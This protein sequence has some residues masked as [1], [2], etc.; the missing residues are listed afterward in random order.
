M[1]KATISIAILC[2]VFVSGKIQLS[3]LNDKDIVTVPNEWSLT[4]ND[5]PFMKLKILHGIISFTRLRY[6]CT[7]Q[8]LI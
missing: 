3:I 5:M 4:L 2:M 7:F 6:V 1:N 8:T